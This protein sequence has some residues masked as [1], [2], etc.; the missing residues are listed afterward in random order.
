MLILRCTRDA[1]GIELVIFISIFHGLTDLTPKPHAVTHHKW[2]YQHVRNQNTQE[3][4]GCLHTELLHSSRFKKIQFCIINNDKGQLTI[5]WMGIL[6]GNDW[7]FNGL[8]DLSGGCLSNQPPWLTPSIV[9]HTK[10]WPTFLLQAAV[11]TLQIGS[12]PI[13][14]F[15]LWHRLR[16]TARRIWKLIRLLF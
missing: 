11:C 14:N 3:S 1:A 4:L 16:C 15:L 10:L 2:I 12:Y 8:G 6:R 13:S 7:N 9:G 5:I